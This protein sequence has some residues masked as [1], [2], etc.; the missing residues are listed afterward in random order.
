[1]EFL[2]KHRSYRLSSASEL[3]LLSVHFLN[4]LIIGQRHTQQNLYKYELLQVGNLS[5]LWEN[6]KINKTNIIITYIYLNIPDYKH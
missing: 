1:M 5:I 4:D 6:G 2:I 3:K